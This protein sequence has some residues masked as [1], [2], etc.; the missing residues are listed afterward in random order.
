[1]TVNSIEK[2]DEA[3]E[4]L[5]KRSGRAIKILV[6]ALIIIT[7]TLSGAVGFLI[8][9]NQGETARIN[10]AVT[11]SAA[12]QQ[13]RLDTQCDFYSLLGEAP[14]MPTAGKL[15]TEWVVDSRNVYIGLGCSPA[16][17]PPSIGLLSLTKKYNIKI[18]G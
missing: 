15:V 16:L 8:N 13:H 9:S 4:S 18:I 10:I 11:K 17:T 14:L 2:A 7:L 12:I 5:T 1:M 3:L 6:S